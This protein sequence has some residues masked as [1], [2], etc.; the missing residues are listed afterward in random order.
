MKK[1]RPL[2]PPGFLSIEGRLG[3]FSAVIYGRESVLRPSL[4]SSDLRY[5]DGS[6]VLGE[7]TASED[8][9]FRD[10]LD[11]LND[12]AHA[13]ACIAAHEV[14]HS[15]GLSHDTQAGAGIMRPTISRYALSDRNFQFGSASAAVLDRSLQKD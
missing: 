7:G 1:K 15:V 6:Y 14:G 8:R 12:W 11:A 4:R 13:L 2:Q 10:V 3:V 9:R 5:L